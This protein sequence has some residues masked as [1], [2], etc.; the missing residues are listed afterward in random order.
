MLLALARR[1]SLL[2]VLALAVASAG[3]VAP[4]VAGGHGHCLETP[5]QHC[6]PVVPP[7]K[8]VPPPARVGLAEV[9]LPTLSPPL[10][11]FAILKIPL[12]V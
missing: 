11:I 9:R 6:L 12:P 10:V 4:A 8:P 1:R 2:V 3:L 5:D 7:G